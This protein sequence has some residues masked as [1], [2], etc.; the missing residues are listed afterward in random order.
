MWRFFKDF[1]IYGI[2]SIIG[3]IAA[4]FL[5]P[6]YTSILSPKEY[7]AQALIVSFVLFFDVFANLNIHSGVGREYYETPNG[8]KKELVS[9]GL[10]SVLACSIPISICLI[11]SSGWIVRSVLGVPD[12]QTEFCIFVCTLVATSC[13][14]YFSVLTRYRKKPI[15]FTIGTGIKVVIQMVISIYGVVFLRVGIISIMI[16]S[17]CSEF[18]GALFYGYIN[19]ANIGLCFNKKIIRRV[20]LFS[21]PTI[22]AI[23]AGWLDS[24]LGQILIG[25]YVSVEDAGVY[26]IALHI[27]SG[28]SLI[29]IA[30]QNVWS[31]FLYENYPKRSFVEDVQRL[32]SIVMLLLILVSVN[33][34]MLSK[35]IILVLSNELYVAAAQYLTL[36]C[37]PLSIYV[38][39]PFASSGV[40]ISRDTKYIGISY[41]IGSIINVL[42]L[43]I[44]LPRY[45]VVCVPIA[46]FVSRVFTFYFLYLVTKIKGLLTLPQRYILY[47][48]VSI[49]VC[50]C[51]NIWGASFQCRVFVLF[52]FDLLLFLFIY[53]KYN[54]KVFILTK[55]GKK[56]NDIL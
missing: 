9:T 19:K 42:L 21:L 39:F 6:I 4:I 44:F 31:P 23:V 50:Y 48:V 54:L 25:K 17:L 43:C 5:M 29:T 52:I 1:F 47:L 36:L 56:E 26:S 8:Q 46:L 10:F 24:S 14:T 30:F 20:L 45:G 34:S 13:Q 38:T 41:V 2:A 11:A 15:L 7:G 53:Q 3:K 12:Y 40:S 16:G 33:I 22:P 27:A 35:E 18:F 28:F 51:A 32:Y 49:I 55:L 37:L